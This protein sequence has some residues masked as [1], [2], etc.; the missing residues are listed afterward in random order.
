M[1]SPYYPFKSLKPKKQRSKDDSKLCQLQLSVNKS[2]M[3]HKFSDSH[4]ICCAISP[5]EKGGFHKCIARF[6]TYSSPGRADTWF[7]SLSRKECTGVRYVITKFSRMEGLPNFLTHGAPLARFA[8]RS[9]AI[10]GRKL[11]TRNAS[12]VADRQAG[13]NQINRLSVR[14]WLCTLSRTTWTNSSEGKPDIVVD[15]DQ[16]YKIT[17]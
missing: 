11:S 7:P 6:L 4:A 8:R 2:Q 3:L 10:K 5:Q 16:Q 1:P 12:R 15:Q 14:V 17:L 13:L 9:S